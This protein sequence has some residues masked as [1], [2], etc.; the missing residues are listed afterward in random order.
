MRKRRSPRDEKQTELDFDYTGEGAS[1]LTMAKRC[2]HGLDMLGI[3]LPTQDL[4][5]CFEKVQMGILARSH[6]QRGDKPWP[7]VRRDTGTPQRPLSTTHVQTF[8]TKAKPYRSLQYILRKFGWYLQAGVPRLP[9]TSHPK[10]AC[11]V[12]A[13]RLP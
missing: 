7:G 3:G 8:H 10:L 11:I 9:V 1:I 5:D 2:D 6:Q 12:M 13:K 4:L